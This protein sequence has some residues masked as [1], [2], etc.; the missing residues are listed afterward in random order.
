MPLSSDFQQKL[1]SEKRQSLSEVVLGV[2]ENKLTT[3]FTLREKSTQNKP[4]SLARFKMGNTRGN[5]PG[6]RCDQD[7]SESSG[8]DKL[9]SWTASNSKASAIEGDSGVKGQVTKRLFIQ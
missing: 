1:V 9:T 6:Y 7:L 2:L 5:T 3:H 8:D 4:K